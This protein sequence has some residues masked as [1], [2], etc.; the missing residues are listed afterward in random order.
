MGA[1]YI[2]DISRLRVKVTLGCLLLLLILHIFN[3]QHAKLPDSKTC[4][5]LL[6]P[7]GFSTYHQ[8]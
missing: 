5:N 1:S 3:S 8:V 2:Y 7:N 4:I 6:K